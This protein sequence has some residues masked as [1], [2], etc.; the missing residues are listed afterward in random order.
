[1]KNRV[2]INF[3][4]YIYIFKMIKFA[5]TEMEVDLFVKGAIGTIF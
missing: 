3:N 1:M 5:S 2:E 4:I